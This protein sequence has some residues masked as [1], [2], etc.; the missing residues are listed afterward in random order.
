MKLC[1]IRLFIVI[2]TIISSCSGGTRR[3][4]NISRN[5]VGITGRGIDGNSRYDRDFYDDGVFEDNPSASLPIPTS[6]TLKKD[7]KT[8]ANIPKVKD[9]EVVGRNCPDIS[10]SIPV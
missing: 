1:L 9:K 6:Q 5:I 2:L 8:S 10:A 7:S 4:L 3:Q